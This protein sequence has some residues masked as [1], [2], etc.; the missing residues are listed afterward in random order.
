[1]GTLQSICYPASWPPATLAIV[2][3][4]RE[5]AR[6]AR[7]TDSRVIPT[8]VVQ[9]LGDGVN[10]GRQGWVASFTSGRAGNS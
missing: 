9:L 5:E 4:P 10:N 8:V 2:M 6:S 3:H 7:A 1:M